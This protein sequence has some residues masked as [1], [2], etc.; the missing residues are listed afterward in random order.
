M[1]KAGGTSRWARGTRLSTGVLCTVSVLFVCTGSASG[2]GDHELDIHID[3]DPLVRGVAFSTVELTQL[4]SGLAQEERHGGRGTGV[5][6]A[7]AAEGWHRSNSKKQA[8]LIALSALTLPGETP[9]QLAQQANAAASAAAGTFCSGASASA[10]LVFTKVKQVPNSAFV[11]CSASPNGLHGEAITIARANVFGMII[12][13]S[14]TL[15]RSALDSVALHQYRRLPT[16]DTL[17]GSGPSS[18]T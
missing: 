6:I 15:T 4:A 18:A 16:T 7:T 1:M 12:T 9:K 13:S 3:S 10:P 11:E 14:G 8:V 17:T 5:T 2:A